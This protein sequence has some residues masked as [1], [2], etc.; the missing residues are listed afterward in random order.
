MPAPLKNLNS[1]DL[2]L[3]KHLIQLKLNGKYDIP[4]SKDQIIDLKDDNKSWLSLS[5]EY[6]IRIWSLSR[7]LPLNLTLNTLNQLCKILN[8]ESKWRTFCVKLEAKRPCD[9]QPNVSF[10]ELPSIKQ[11]KLTKTIHT[12]LGE[13]SDFNET[14]FSES[15][16]LSKESSFFDQ[17]FKQQLNTSSQFLQGF[18]F[19]IITELETRKAGIP[20][21]LANDT[22][23]D[24]YNSW[25]V[26]FNEIR[27]EIKS[28]PNEINATDHECIIVAKNI[29]DT[30]LRPHLTL[31]QAKFRFWM[32]MQ[33]SNPAN[34][35]LSPQEIQV[36]FPHFKEL[37]A[38]LLNSNRLL[39]EY[40]QK[41]SNSLQ[42]LS[43]SL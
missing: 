39:M 28:L 24:I 4:L 16:H 26:L 41:L 8:P 7:S 35:E 19:R 25:Y 11:L 18:A 30:A 32:N 31:Y 2:L 23:E 17:Q 10:E 36:N 12:L 21:N 27:K 1:F 5:P 3:L 20:I 9:I 15:R 37:N 22:I 38:S 42:G 6:L 33:K 43:N 40:H 13:Y 14:E 34:S 29:L